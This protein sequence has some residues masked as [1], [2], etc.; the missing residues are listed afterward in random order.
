[1]PT[2]YPDGMDIEIFNFKKLKNTSYN[3]KL[4]AEN[5]HSTIYM[6]KSGMLKN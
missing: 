5:E 6:W 1:M 3:A 2:N 4:L